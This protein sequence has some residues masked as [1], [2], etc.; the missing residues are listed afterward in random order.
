MKEYAIEHRPF[1][2]DDLTAP[3][4]PLAVYQQAHEGMVIACH[5]VMIYLED[6]E[7]WLLIMRKNNPAQDFL[8]PLGGRLLRGMSTEESIR[9]RVRKESKLELYDVEIVGQAR[10]YF[11]TDPFGHGKG[12][13]TLNVLLC[14]K[15]KGEI[16]LDNLHEH[17]TFIQKQ[18]YTPS[19]IA[20]LH[21]YVQDLFEL[22]WAYIGE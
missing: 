16:E 21:V 2:I 7:A 8:W 13:D 22:G 5:D 9:N 12:T 6:R 4:L 1:Q 15:A 11:H 19:F 18:D 20:S 17:P 3:L 14:A 10:T